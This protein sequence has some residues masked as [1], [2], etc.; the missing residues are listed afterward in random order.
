MSNKIKSNVFGE[1][2]DGIIVIFTWGFII[3][4]PTTVISI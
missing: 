2:I 4:L 1:E 3:T